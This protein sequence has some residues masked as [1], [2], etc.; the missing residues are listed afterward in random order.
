MHHKI[1]PNVRDKNSDIWGDLLYITQKL[2]I[3]ISQT[4]FQATFSQV[5]HRAS[6]TSMPT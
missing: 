1:S 4:Y 5:H 6:D 3:F 2:F